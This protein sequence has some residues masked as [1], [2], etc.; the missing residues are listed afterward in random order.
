MKTGGVVTC[1]LP[2][3]IYIQDDTA[4]LLV[5]TSGPITVHPGDR[6]EVVG[7]PDH[8]SSGLMLS[9]A[10]IRRIA[11]AGLPDPIPFSWKGSTKQKFGDL[12][13]SLVA[14][15]LAQRDVSGAQLLTLEMGK[16]IFEAV[17]VADGNDRLAQIPVG[18]RVAI[19]GVC[20]MDAG[21][22][23][24]GISESDAVPVVTS[25]KI[26]L[27]ASTDVTVL[28]RPPRWTLKRVAWFGALFASGFLGTLVWVRMLRRSVA[29]KTSELQATMQRLE[30]EKLTS[31]VLAE[32]DRLA[33]E[34]HDSLEQGLTAIMMQLD[35][36]KKHADESSDVRRI[37]S[38]AR[39]MAEFSRA[40]VQHAVWDMQ[41]PLLA[42]ADLDTALKQVADQICSGASEVKVEIL[43][44]PGRPLSSSCEHHLLRIA[45][46]AM[47]NA[48]KHAQAQSIKVVLDYSEC[49][50]KLAIS[51]DGVGFDPA[52]V[53]QFEQNGHFG[54]HGM[55]ARVKKINAQLEIASQPGKGTVITVQMK[56][57]DGHA[58]AVPKENGL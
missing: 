17:R 21:L 1:V 41:S 19:T 29:Q 47:T 7:F 51:D 32:R 33:G 45:Q 20:Q 58:D 48:V 55:Q 43:G 38:L 53:R 15:V 16:S 6:V 46:E 12:L 42:N 8:G 56:W 18:S 10:S 30:Q 52:A 40:E 37:I 49:R 5:Q 3:G 14:T 2:K 11:A 24:F 25:L 36:A 23:D 9:G 44:Q 13:V 27:P 35:A 50:L 4:G 26:W 28:E 57:D 39:N 34:I 31:A 22:I 54:L